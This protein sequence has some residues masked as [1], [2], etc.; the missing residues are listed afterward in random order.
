MN[1]SES[2]AHRALVCLQKVL[3]AYLAG[4]ADAGQV[5]SELGSVTVAIEILDFERTFFL[6]FHDG[7]LQLKQRVDDEASIQARVSAT[8]KDFASLCLRQGVHGRFSE[9][10][11]RGDTTTVQKLWNTLSK[12]NFNCETFLAPQVGDVVAHEL[13][14][15]AQAGARFLRRSLRSLMETTTEYLQEEIQLA[16]KAFRVQRFIHQVD[17]LRDD[18]DRLQA[19]IR[20]W[21]AGRE[22]P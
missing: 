14:R 16:P 11:I 13:G 21:E 18:V 15:G 7:V 12:I 1:V 3:D 5:L 22:Q 19:R 17:V 10:T 8:L 20:Q 6:V 9:L 4:D 2:T